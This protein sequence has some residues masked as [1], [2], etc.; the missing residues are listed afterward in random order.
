[1]KKITLIALAVCLCLAAACAQALTATGLETETV[2]RPWETS[3]F[4][5]RMQALTG[6]E[7][8]AHGVTDEEE[9]Q[10]LLADMALGEIP[11]DMLFKASLT[12]T[13]ER[14]LLESGALI[15]LAPLIEE[16][17][18]NLSALLAAHPQ[19]RETISLDDGR[20]ASLPLIN[21]HERQVCVWINRTWLEK[22]GLEM[23]TTVD[24][25]TGALAAIRDGDP[26]ANG[27][28]D[29][30]AAD[31]M[32]VFEMRWLLPYFGIV[33]DDY[34]LARQAD[35]T[36]CFAP[37]LPGYR[38]FIA[39]LRDWT[40]QGILADNAFTG[41]HSTLTL[42][43]GS[44]DETVTSGLL[45]TATPY[46]HV[47][48]EAVT[49]YEPLLMAGPD[50]TIRWRDMLGPVWTG[51][52]AVTSACGDPASAL[53]W[54]DALYAQEG[55]VLGYG[56]V[57][58]EDYVFDENGRWTFV[59]D[60][61]RTVDDIRA[62]VL[63]YTGAAMPGI[64]PSDFVGSV[65][66]EIDQHVF[67]GNERVLAVSE[68]VMPAY[69]LDEAA[70]ARADELAVTLGG[71]VDR[72]IARFATGEVELND[73]TYAAWLD[74]LRAAGSGELTELFRAAR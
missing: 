73:D 2:N 71:L 69:L 53:R 37:E 44:Q 38:E 50:G 40:Q 3:V 55:A 36:L 21:E 11:A 64:Y 31:L 13:Q 68:Q 62:E 46:T 10:K 39:T 32:G 41:V 4:F 18:P 8:Q 34:N 23:P 19:W 27:K 12:R 57:E 26:N 63:M 1:M 9:Y 45:V 51:C 60:A 29:E 58:G 54:V 30:A 67:A 35:G 22:L 15:D 61:M 65:G 33:A 66:S 56:G 5:S 74:E 42:S 49:D 17:M 28:R 70:Q 14:E 72:G 25:L 47:P 24:E 20:I 48:A 52:F 7:V 43:T 6:V 16:N 59:T